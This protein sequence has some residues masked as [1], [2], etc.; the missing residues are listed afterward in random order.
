MKVVKLAQMAIIM[1]SLVSCLS[2]KS[3]NNDG[4]NNNNNVNNNRQNVENAP[5][6]QNAAAGNQ[7]NQGKNGIGN[8]YTKSGSIQIHADGDIVYAVNKVASESLGAPGKGSLSIIKVKTGNIDTSEILAEIPVGEDPFSVSVSSDGRR[9]FVSNGA[10]NTVSYIAGQGK[11]GPFRKLKEIVVGSEPRG[12]AFSSDESKLYVA[13]FSDGTLSVLDSISGRFLNIVRLRFNNVFIKNPYALASTKQTLYVTDFYGRYRTN[14]PVDRREAFDDGKEGRVGIINMA[15]DEMDGHLV[16]SPLSNAGFPADRTAFSGAGNVYKSNQA[17]P[18]KDFQGAFFNQLHDIEFDA[19]SKKLYFP[20][21]AAAPEPPVKFNVN[22]Q[23]VVGVVDNTSKS[24]IFGKHVNLNNLIK[25]ETNPTPPFVVGNPNRLDRAFAADTMAMALK[26]GT[27]LFV[28]RAGSFV[29]RGQINA[30]GDISL[31]KRNATSNVRIPV[32]N[33]PTGVVINSNATRAYVYAEVSSNVTV[34]NLNNNSVLSKIDSSKTPTSPKVRRNLLGKL[35]FYTGMGLPAGVTET[36]DP[37]LIDTLRHR[38]MASDNNWSSCASC[39][40]FGLADGITW[41]FPTGPR[42]TVPLEG[43]FAPGSG[44]KTEATTD[45][46]VFNWNGVRASVTDF[47]NNARGVQGGHGFSPLSLA[48]IDAGGEKTD[49]TDAG[50]AENHGRRLGVSN[51]LDF[52]TEWVASK[53]RVFNRPTEI[54]NSKAQVGRALFVQKC[55]SCHGG[56]K[57]TSSRREMDDLTLWPDPLFVGG[58]LQSARIQNPAATVV[59]AIDRDGDGSFEFQILKTAPEIAT[60]DLNNPIEVRGLGPLV[61]QPSAPGG[62]SF[63]PPS[64]LN[65]YNSAPYGHHGRAQTLTQVFDSIAGGGLG[66]NKFG[67]SNSEIDFVIEFMK[68]IDGKQVPIPL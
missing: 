40:P 63:N 45:Q 65:V 7:G 24:E 17:D 3:G 8:I 22:I 21:I 54:D 56:R 10:D 67:L 38:N 35:A 9:I 61:G 41:S 47:T 44:F 4:N 66:H 42:Q 18:T 5:P 19:G 60:L 12:T 53:V 51:A 36:T 31:V 20:S 29:F 39:H 32:G 57:W 23:A 64:L 6:A 37:K 30:S 43:S 15:N 49:V 1:F 25:T 26:N 34:I 33:I 59:K 11:F 68:T 48:T 58:V 13:N 62:A 16:L 14:L 28:S 46:R 50:L 27:A 52:M 55:A 2:K